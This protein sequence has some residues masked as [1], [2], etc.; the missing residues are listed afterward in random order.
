MNTKTVILASSLLVIIKQI[1]KR[2][3]STCPYP[4]ALKPRQGPEGPEC[5]QGPQR[6]DGRKL[7]VAQSIGYEADQGHLNDKR[8]GK[9]RKEKGPTEQCLNKIVN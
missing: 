9:V 3:F 1:F 5:S 6:L 7:R 4:H 8:G 2:C